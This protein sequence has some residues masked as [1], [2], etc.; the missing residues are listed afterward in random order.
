M[1]YFQKLLLEDL[2][3]SRICNTL[4]V[5]EADEDVRWISTGAKGKLKHAPGIS[6]TWDICPYYYY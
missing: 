5:P 4:L 1:V 3:E 6:K 2:D